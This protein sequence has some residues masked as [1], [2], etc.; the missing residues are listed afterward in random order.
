[1]TRG[2]SLILPAG[3]LDVI[4]YG[5]TSGTIAM[6]EATIARRIR[7]VRPGIAVTTPFT[8]VLAGL[9]ALQA[10]HT[11]LLT[12]YSL[13]VTMTM[14]DF[15]ERSGIEVVRAA[16]F[17]LKLDSEMNRVSPA[18]IRRAVHELDDADCE[19]VFV[20]CTAL[21][22]N[23]VIEELERAL[24]KPVISS[25]QALAWHALRLAG[26]REQVANFGRLLRL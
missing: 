2:A 3:R 8:A 1:L 16:T 25:N 6:G 19:A 4:A 5:C 21:R 22:A 12:P 15:L 13:P 9:A 18:S 7:E 24:G 11:I 10:R 14:C 23:G 20:C 26:Y 17:D